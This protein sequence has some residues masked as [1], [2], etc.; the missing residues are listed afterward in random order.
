MNTPLVSIIITTH[1]RPVLLKRAI[2]SALAQTYPNKE[3]IVVDDN[4][5]DETQLVCRNYSEIRYINITS[6]ESKGGNYA[7]NIGIKASQGYYVELLDDDDYWLPEK[8]LSQVTLLENNDQC[9]I[10]YTNA[11]FEEVLI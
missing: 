6:Q 11:Y 9:G 5:D 1:N 7:R 8:T 3:I 10:C 2:E 4:S